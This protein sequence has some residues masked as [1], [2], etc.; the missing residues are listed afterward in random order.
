MNLEHLCRLVLL[1]YDKLTNKKL[2]IAFVSYQFKLLA[3]KKNKLKLGAITFEIKEVR[4]YEFLLWED[5]D[6]RY[7]RQDNTESDELK[8]ENILK[9]YAWK[10]DFKN[11]FALILV[12]SLF[13]VFLYALSYCWYCDNLP[14]LAFR[15]KK[16]DKV[17]EFSLQTF[18]SPT[19]VGFIKKWVILNAWVNKV[20]VEYCLAFNLFF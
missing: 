4:A 3:W 18:F 10:W 2:A 6:I 12:G 16:L 11:V 7:I 8:L 1:N 17:V 13:L 5:I 15:D 20:L 14:S 9:S 19:P